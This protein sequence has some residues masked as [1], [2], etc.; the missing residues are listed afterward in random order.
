MTQS[1][2]MF[3]LAGPDPLVTKVSGYHRS[4]GFIFSLRY[5]KVL[6]FAH[7]SFNHM[8]NCVARTDILCHSEFAACGKGVGSQES[9]VSVV[10]SADS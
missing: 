3:A 2:F 8:A 10:V 9:A 5:T 6:A 4:K 7:P 1:C